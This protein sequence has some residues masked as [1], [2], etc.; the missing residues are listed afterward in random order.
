M[1]DRVVLDTVG[2]LEVFEGFY[3]REVG[4]STPST[5]FVRRPSRLE[6][7][8]SL[9]RLYSVRALEQ[10][11]LL[12]DT[13]RAEGR[14]EQPGFSTTTKCCAEE[15]SSSSLTTRSCPLIL[16]GCGLVSTHT[17]DPSGSRCTC[18]GTVSTATRAVS[19]LSLL[20]LCHVYALY[21]SCS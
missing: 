9:L 15:E 7:L 12:D 10:L 2:G 5:S 18:V 17:S 11:G 1:A 21:S 19:C 8:G 4:L 14:V 6:Q 3:F 13:V 20:C 16:C